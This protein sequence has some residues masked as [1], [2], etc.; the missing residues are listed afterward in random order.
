MMK[1]NLCK[2]TN[3]SVD[4]NIQVVPEKAGTIVYFNISKHILM[5]V[6]VTCDINSHVIYKVDI[7]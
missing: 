4:H 2:N 7:V 5:H 1:S 3:R 6:H